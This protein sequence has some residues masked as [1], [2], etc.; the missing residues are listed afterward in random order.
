MATS[1]S[2][3][4]DALHRV[5]FIEGTLPDGITALYADLVNEYGINDVLV[6]KRFSSGTETIQDELR[7]EIDA[8]EQPRVESLV[9]HAHRTIDR[10]DDP[11]HRLSSYERS[12]LFKQFLDQWEWETKYLDDASVQDS[13]TGDVEQFSVVA[14]WQGPPVTND[15]VLGELTEAHTAFQ[16]HLDESDHLEHARVVHAAREVAKNSTV[17]VTSPSAVI[18]L[19]A[20]DY[21]TAERAY[22]KEFTRNTQTHWVVV[23]QSA[24]QRTRNESGEIRVDDLGDDVETIDHPQRNIESL[25]DAVAARLA[26]GRTVNINGERGHV[27]VLNTTTFD[28]QIRAVAEE[29]ELLREEESLRYDDIAIVLKD[30]RSPIREVIESLNRRGIPTASTTVSGL[31]ND[32]SVRELYTVTRTLAESEAVEDDAN[33]LLDTRVGED[34]PIGQ[35]ESADSLVEGLWEWIHLTGLKRRIAEDEPEIDAR[36]QFSHVNDIVELAEFAD[37][38]PLIEPT[39]DQFR[40]LIEFSFEHAAPD[41]YGEDIDSTEGGVLVDTAQRIKTGKWDTVFVVNAVDQEYPSDP[42]VNRLFPRSHLEKIPEYP[43]VSAPTGDEVKETFDTATSVDTRPFCAYYSHYS[44]RLM[45]VAARGAS[46]RLYFT[47]Y[48]ERRSDPGKYRRPSRFLIDLLEEF[49]QITEVAERD[50]RTESRAVDH[51]LDSIDRT[52]DEIR[53]APTADEQLDL[54]EIERNFGAIQRLLAESERGDEIAA[55]ITARADFAEGV[56]RR[57]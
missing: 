39:W 51:S 14:S 26:T 24:V 18:V 21:T 48:R 25:V 40:D 43:M 16:E 8:V 10:L 32:P 29:I 33:A 57:E 9:R 54:T 45:G 15:E 38:S 46:K 1:A 55:A 50:I 5:D 34:P 20:E 31:R 35:I 42:R 52:L 30:N 19:E 13:F 4:G 27:A 56:V 37:Q 41:G 53:R 49:P 17:E 11:P 7:T 2:L 44:R 47:T 36:A 23:E 12:F 3:D 6:L 22:V 28:E